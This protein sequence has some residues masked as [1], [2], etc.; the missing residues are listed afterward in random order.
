MWGVWMVL[1]RFL[2]DNT[3][4]LKRKNRLC[5]KKK[6]KNVQ[7][8]QGRRPLH[9][10]TY[11]IYWVNAAHGFKHL[12]C[13]TILPK[14]RNAMRPDLRIHFPQHIVN[15]TEFSTCLVC[16]YTLLFPSP[17]FQNSFDNKIELSTSKD[18]DSHLVKS[19]SHK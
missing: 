2:S 16:K 15:C 10:C 19:T 14:S 9:P 17:S 18:V 5:C 6:A 7:K 1:F 4:Y 12:P 11:N 8:T 13:S 3:S